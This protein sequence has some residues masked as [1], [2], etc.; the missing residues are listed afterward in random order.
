MTDWRRVPKK[1]L[2]PSIIEQAP[3]DIDGAGI[4]VRGSA[5]DEYLVGILS[6]QLS[7]TQ[8]ENDRLKA[9]RSIEDVKAGMLE[10]YGDRVY[11]FVMGYCIVVAIFLIMSGYKNY[12]QFQLNDTILAIIAGSTAVAV[13]GLIGMVVSGL[14]GSSQKTRE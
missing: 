13:I 4:S 14:F 5:D 9:Q 12:T 1:L 7:E 3:V 10:T 2:D 6:E 11:Y 8:A